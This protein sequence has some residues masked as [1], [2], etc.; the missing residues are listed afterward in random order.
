M[1]VS[2]GKKKRLIDILTYFTVPPSTNKKSFGS[3]IS[4]NLGLPLTDGWSAR[5][6]EMVDDVLPLILESHKQ[7]HGTIA[8]NGLLSFLQII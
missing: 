7:I 8:M 2:V 4:P 6:G 1:P 5:L 3:Y